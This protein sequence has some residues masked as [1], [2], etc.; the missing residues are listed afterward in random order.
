MM[1]RTFA[2][3][4]GR[5]QR[6]WDHY[7]FHARIQDE[8]QTN[9]QLFERKEKEEVDRLENQRMVSRDRFREEDD[10]ERQ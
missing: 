2:M 9:R 5:G 4:S 8:K 6:T 1:K 7:H 10:G 3:M